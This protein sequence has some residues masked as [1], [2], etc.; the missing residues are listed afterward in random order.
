MAR[1]PWRKQKTL[2]ML[3]NKRQWEREFDPST[4]LE[5]EIVLENGDYL[6]TQASVYY[7]PTYIITE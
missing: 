2:A 3:A 7:V 5:T 4:T 6:V 1:L